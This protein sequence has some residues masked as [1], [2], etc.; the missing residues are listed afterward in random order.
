MLGTDRDGERYIEHD[1]IARTES[2]D[3]WGVVRLLTFQWSEPSSPRWEKPV[4]YKDRRS[5]EARPRGCFCMQQWKPAVIE[6]WKFDWIFKATLSATP[7]KGKGLIEQI[8]Q[9][10]SRQKNVAACMTLRKL[11]PFLIPSQKNIKGMV[12]K[13]NSPTALSHLPGRRTKPQYKTFSQTSDRRVSGKKAWVRW[14]GI[15]GF[16]VKATYRSRQLRGSKSK[17]KTTI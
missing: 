3:W 13:K 16:R 9:P 5:P 7:K 15:P 8:S 17:L 10:W 1:G 11:I 12:K 14:A 6:R 4:R 2:T